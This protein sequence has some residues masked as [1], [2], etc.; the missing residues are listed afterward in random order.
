MADTPPSAARERTVWVVDDDEAIRFVLSEALRDSGVRVR[1]FE[2][3]ESF[4]T[5]FERTQPDAI[6]SDVRM[7][8]ASGLDLLKRLRERG[9]TTPVIVMSAFTDV[10]RPRRRIAMARSTI[11]QSP[12]TSIRQCPLSNARWRRIMSRQCLR[13]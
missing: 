1:A 7:P 3:A 12:S 11:C 5:A 9:A 6:I 13:L 10:A 2:D 8:G 4:M